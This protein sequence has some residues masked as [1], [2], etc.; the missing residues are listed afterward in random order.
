MIFWIL[1]VVLYI[2]TIIFGL[3]VDSKNP[4]K[5]VKL[6]K[7]YVVWL[8]I[9]LC[10]GYMVG[11][12]WRSYESVYRTG[13][14]LER[15]SSEPVSYLL[16]SY[17]PKIIPDYWVFSGIA[18]CAYLFS[19]QILISR[20]TNKWISVLAILI[21]LQLAF[22]LIQNPFRFMVS[23]F[24]LNIA[25]CYLYKYLS[26]TNK[27]GV[28]KLSIVIIF[29]L[30]AALAHNSSIIYL[31]LF[32]LFLFSRKIKDTNR[33]LLFS[34]FIIVSIITSNL[35]FVQELK[36]NTIAL[37]LQYWNISD[38]SNYDI[39]QTGTFFSLA[40]L[41]KI[42]FFGFVLLSRDL[43]INKYKSGGIVYNLTV[44]YFFTNY[45]FSMIPTGFRLALPLVP[46]C[47]IY[48]VY[49]LYSKAI[50]FQIIILY[51]LLSFGNRLWTLYD[52]IPY[53]NSIPYF[54]VGH[55]NYNER[56]QY[57]LIEYKERIGEDYYIE[58]NTAL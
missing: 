50:Y 29:V 42:L 6:R 49:I 23:T 38:Y 24:F 48:Y 53:T 30:L 34:L 52:F 20:I 16:F 15:Y 55:K 41:L 22:M 18:K 17:L 28:K 26:Y 13:F 51:T 46:F 54:F 40:N 58:K 43:V 5:Y 37:V 8:Y 27:I 3:Y 11:S 19:I 21:P 9:F 56:Y 2:G 25:L 33:I 31:F 12:D 35:S 1:S 44:I 39:E 57:N 47:V 45:I 32:P 10:F 36:L 14:G 7:A 4:I